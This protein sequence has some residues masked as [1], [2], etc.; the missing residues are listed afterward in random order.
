MEVLVHGVTQKG[1][2]GIP[3]CVTQQELT[4]Q[5]A[6]E[7]VQGT[8]KAAKLEGDLHCPCLI[9]SSVYDMKPVH[10]LSMITDTIKWIT[11]E[12]PVYNVDMKQVELMQFL[13]L[14][15]IDTYNFGMGNVDIADQL[16][17]LYRVDI[18]LHNRKW[19]WSIFSWAFG[20]FITNA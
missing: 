4:N 3:S 2:H 12:R 11:K 20:V 7:Q 6:I 18:W 8:V 9:A 5:T 16:R 17:G 13:Q 14:N 19:W 15:Q 1:R 10:Y